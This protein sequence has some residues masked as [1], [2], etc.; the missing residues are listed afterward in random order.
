MTNLKKYTYIT[1]NLRQKFDNLQIDKKKNFATFN[2][3]E[4]KTGCNSLFISYKWNSEDELCTAI[5]SPKVPA[6]KFE[7]S[8]FIQAAIHKRP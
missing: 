6:I 1:Q 5:K 4:D 8:K 3:L 7:V 2:N